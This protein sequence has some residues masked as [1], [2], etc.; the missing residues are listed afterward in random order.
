HEFGVLVDTH[1]ADGIKVGLEQRE[2][3][4][5]LICLETALPAKFAESIEEAVGRSPPRPR[6][7]ERL[8]DLPRRFSVMDPDTAQIKA[9]IADRVIAAAA[10]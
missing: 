6:G 9:F 8:E 3:G 4:I 1:T 5:P 7:F 2:A 10:A